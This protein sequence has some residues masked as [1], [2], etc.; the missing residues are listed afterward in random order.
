M[1]IGR[2]YPKPPPEHDWIGERLG[3]KKPDRASEILGWVI[4]LPIGILALASIILG[5]L[6]QCVSEVRQI[7]G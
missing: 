7:T 5:F 4:G 2:K 1:D 6:G 3:T